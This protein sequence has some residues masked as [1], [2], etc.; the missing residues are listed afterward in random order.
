[1]LIRTRTRKKEN[2]LL[3]VEV[4][5]FLTLVKHKTS[6]PPCVGYISQSFIKNGNVDSTER[7]DPEFTTI[8]EQR[9]TIR[10]KLFAILIKYV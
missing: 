7:I 6:P 3:E 2:E 10:A 8:L 5:T 4:A 9:K 1:M